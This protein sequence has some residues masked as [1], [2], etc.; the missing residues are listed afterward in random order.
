MKPGEDES[1]RAC[2][3][4]RATRLPFVSV[5]SSIQLWRQDVC[6]HHERIE[7]IIVKILI[8]TR[9]NLRRADE[10]R[11]RERE[12]GIQMLFQTRCNTGQNAH[13]SSSG[14]GRRT[15]VHSLF[16][17]LFFATSNPTSYSD[18]NGRARLAARAITVSRGP[19][20]RE[21]C[22]NLCPPSLIF[23]LA[24]SLAFYGPFPH[25]RHL[26]SRP[27]YPHPSL[28]PLSVLRET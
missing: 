5:D 26:L 21:K 11:E 1:V 9:I 24:L 3:L 22:L 19:K 18:I 10:E 17:L 20:L 27:Q 2:A 13:P 25:P 4:Q 8:T 12:R 28:F 14:P 6:L 7:R 23:H 16:H 15:S